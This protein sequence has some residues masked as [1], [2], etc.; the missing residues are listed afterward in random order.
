MHNFSVTLLTNGSLLESHSD[1]LCNLRN[2]NRLHFS[3]SLDASTPEKNARTRGVNAFHRTLKGIKRLV[4]L[5]YN[6]N[7]LCTLTSFFNIGELDEIA[8]LAHEYGVKQLQ[9]TPLQPSGKGKK[10]FDDLRPSNH[11]L[12]KLLQKVPEISN[13]RHINIGVGFGKCY[14]ETFDERKNYN[15]LPCKAGITQI[16][17]TSNGDV[18]PCNALNIY[19]GNILKQSIDFIMNDSE[20]AKRI[21]YITCQTIKHHSLCNKCNYSKMCTGGCRGIGYGYFDDVLAPDIYC[22]HIH[23]N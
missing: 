7:V 19:M 12:T 15:L 18:Y 22:D 2:K 14:D 23:T 21:Q 1:F 8:K 6:V 9:L 13:N 16:S 11:L 5:G 10:I 17:V 20:G 3:V 4:E